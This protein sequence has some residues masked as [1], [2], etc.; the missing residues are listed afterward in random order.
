MIRVDKVENGYQFSQDVHGEWLSNGK[1]YSKEE[2]QKYIL[3][4]FD[5]MITTIVKYENKPLSDQDGPWIG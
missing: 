4:N 1:I 2:A 3:R 5:E